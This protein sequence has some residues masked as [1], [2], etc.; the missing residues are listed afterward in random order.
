ML[1]DAL[2]ACYHTRGF[3]L[4]STASLC[5]ETGTGGKEELGVP[6]VSPVA[7]FGKGS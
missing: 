2:T 6:V 1:S 4:D 7:C 3:V 5:S